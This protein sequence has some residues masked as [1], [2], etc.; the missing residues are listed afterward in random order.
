MNELIVTVAR[1]LTWSKDEK[2]EC[3]GTIGQRASD[4][5]AK[6]QCGQVARRMAYAW[7]HEIRG[8]GDELKGRISDEFEVKGEVRVCVR[9]KFV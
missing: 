5:P 1:T 8:E 3:V 2:V 9:K 4:I 7:S 6:R